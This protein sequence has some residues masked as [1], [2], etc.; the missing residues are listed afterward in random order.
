[1]DSRWDET[2]ALSTTEM[3]ADSLWHGT[4]TLQNVTETYIHV[5]SP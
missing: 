5:N 4:K 3:M 1:M 2:C